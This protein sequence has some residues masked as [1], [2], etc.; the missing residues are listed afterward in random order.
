MWEN[1]YATIE[2]ESKRQV[3]SS[4]WEAHPIGTKRLAKILG[5]AEKPSLSKNSSF[6]T[7]N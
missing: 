2:T 5:T 4:H 6:R 7:V 3:Q 1:T